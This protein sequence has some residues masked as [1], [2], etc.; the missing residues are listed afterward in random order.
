[1]A[2]YK[3]DNIGITLASI[4]VV[5]KVISYLQE[6]R[7][8]EKEGRAVGGFGTTSEQQ[9]LQ[10]SRHEI[11]AAVEQRSISTQT[12]VV[13]KTNLK[14]ATSSPRNVN[15]GTSTRTN[16]RSTNTNTNSNTSNIINNNNNEDGYLNP[17]ALTSSSSHPGLTEFHSWMSAITE[18]YRSYSIPKLGEEEGLTILP[19][20]EHG[21]VS[22]EIRITNNLFCDIDIYWINYKGKEQLRGTIGSRGSNTGRNLHRIQTWVGHPWAFRRR[23]NQQLLLHFVPYR[24]LPLTFEEAK[25][26]EKDG[27]DTT[28]G[29]YEFS[30]NN[31]A[32]NEQNLACSIDDEIIPYPST[33]IR[34]I[35]HALEFSCQQ[36][37]RED[38]SPS[39]LLKYLYNIAL[40][41]C[42]SKYRQI[43]TSNKVFWTNVWC[44]GGRGILHAL[45]FEEKGAYIE[46]G[47]N[48]GPLSGE[49]LKHVADAIVMLEELKKDLED[50]QRRQ[51][52]GRPLGTDGDLGRGG[53]RG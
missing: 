52:Y 41:P 22:V 17:P 19:R 33:K 53:W 25:F 14:K 44:N 30:I 11:L 34:S 45:G 9:Q 32:L 35:N 49:R 15:T 5:H 38:V 27:H 18:I 29:F 10:Q 36:M 16:P 50:S 43:R 13:Q 1:M 20:S 23:D 12:R 24:V 7:A 4:F 26:M 51:V 47:P 6:K 37:E 8:Y 21:R 46:M 2:W 3:W 48:T 39:I 28:L 42:E 31:P 40:H